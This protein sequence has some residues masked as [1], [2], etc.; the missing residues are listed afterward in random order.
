MCI[1]PAEEV[2][3]ICRLVQPSLVVWRRRSPSFEGDSLVLVSVIN[4][5]PPHVSC[6]LIFH[7]HIVHVLAFHTARRGDGYVVVVG[8][9]VAV[10][11]ARALP[12]RAIRLW[13][14]VPSAK[15]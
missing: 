15:G 10:G 5:Q 12:R 8:P 6:L 3:L 13:R 9:A 14:S 7:F 2:V 11:P 1:A 4:P